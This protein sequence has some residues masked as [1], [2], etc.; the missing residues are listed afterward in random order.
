MCNICNIRLPQAMGD[1]IGI[2]IGTAAADSIRY[3]ALARHRSN[4]TCIPPGQEMDQ[5]YSTAPGACMNNVTSNA[6]ST[7]GSPFIN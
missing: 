5:A 2:S 6:R 4:P 3:R 1:G 7:E